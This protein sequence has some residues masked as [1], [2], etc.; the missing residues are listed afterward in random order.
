MLS[1]GVAGMEA[2]ACVLEVEH[3]WGSAAKHASSGM[4]TAMKEAIE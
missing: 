4:A 3:H 1:S 2:L